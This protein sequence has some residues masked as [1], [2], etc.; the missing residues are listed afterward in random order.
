M[1]Q[2]D[3]GFKRED[4]G[5]S[6]ITA[7]LSM[8]AN[9]DG[10]MSVPQL[11][12]Q[13][14]LDAIAGLQFRKQLEAQQARQQM[15]DEREKAK[16]DM[17]MQKGQFELDEANRKAELMK[18]WQAG[19]MEAY[20]MLFP[21][22]WA[23]D[24][25][26]MMKHR[27]ALALEAAKQGGKVAPV[28][29]PVPQASPIVSGS[30]PTAPGAHPVK[31]A[32]DAEPFMT[33]GKVYDFDGNEMQ[34]NGA[35]KW[36]KRE[37]I[38]LPDGRKVI[39]QLDPTGNVFRY[40]GDVRGKKLPL[41]AVNNI[42]GNSAMMGRIRGAG[43]SARKNPDATGPLKG[44]ANDWMPDAVLQ[45]FDSDGTVSRAKIAELGSAIF[46]D[47]SG[48]AVTASEFDRLKPF[49]PQIGDT[50]DTVQK[51]L[52]QFYSIVQE[53]HLLYLESLKESGYDVPE[54]LVERGMKPFDDTPPL[55]GGFVED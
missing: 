22:Q 30:T 17:Q 10:R 4:F 51:K 2:Y 6:L 40:G 20:K 36:G 33:P 27:N 39:G 28:F 47:R 25:R 46:H 11:I 23:A 21:E 3:Y 24:Q 45:W 41:S 52:Q 48:A 26:E 29:S 32:G 50:P 8:L 18:R 42:S 31:P 14:G 54:S 5:P 34:G 43:K 38:I 53:E 44:F 49:I 13:G 12:G 55:P 16:H 35:V 19:D 9:N 15:L 37:E 1:N 7:G